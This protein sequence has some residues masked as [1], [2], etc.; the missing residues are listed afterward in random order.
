MKA[1][2]LKE[3]FKFEDSEYL[4]F[5]DSLEDRDLWLTL[6][7][8]RQIQFDKDSYPSI[9]YK[10][11]RSLKEGLSVAQNQLHVD[12]ETYGKPRRIEEFEKYKKRKKRESILDKFKYILTIKRVVEEEHYKM[13]EMIYTWYDSD[14]ERLAEEK[15]FDPIESRFEILDL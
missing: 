10:N 5:F 8:E 11:P 2:P 14:I 15:I 6:N 1:K 7:A 4:K 12:M 9:N 3:R 13:E